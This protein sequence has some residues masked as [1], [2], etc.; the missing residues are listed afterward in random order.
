MTNNCFLP[1]AA[2]LSLRANRANTMIAAREK[3]RRD[4]GRTPAEAFCNNALES[5][6]FVRKLRGLD[7]RRGPS[8]SGALPY[9]L[10]TDLRIHLPT[11]LFDFRCTRLNSRFLR[12][13]P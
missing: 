7:R 9:L 2:P 1:N 5:N 4:R 10:A 8:L 11:W 12:Y 3:G 6:S 13:G